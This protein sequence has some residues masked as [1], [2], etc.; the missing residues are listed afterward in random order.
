MFLHTRPCQR[1]PNGKRLGQAGFIPP[2]AALPLVYDDSYM[3]INGRQVGEP[4]FV[5]PVLGSGIVASFAEGGAYD[6]NYRDARGRKPGDTGFVP[7]LRGVKAP[8]RVALKAAGLAEGFD[9][10]FRDAKGRRPGEAGFIP[11]CYTSRYTTQEPDVI[12]F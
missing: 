11:P 12:C 4:G 6:V 7:P 9:E 1:D 2:Q 8:E 5:P 3:D 10:D